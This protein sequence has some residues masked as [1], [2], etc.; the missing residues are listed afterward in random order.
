MRIAIDF[1]G[2]ISSNRDMWSDLIRVMQEYGAEVFIVTAREQKANNE[3]IHRYGNAVGVPVVFTGG[4]QKQ[5]FF[6]ADI[7]IDD[8]PSSVVHA[9]D[10]EFMGK[11]L[12]SGRRRSPW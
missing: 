11:A 2:T 7:W 8:N 5:D 10:I 9:H 6:D 12:H 4:A 3:D 1:D